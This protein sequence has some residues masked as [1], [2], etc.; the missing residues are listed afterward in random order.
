MNPRIKKAVSKSIQ[1]TSS[2][3]D[4]LWNGLCVASCLALKWP[5]CTEN[6]AAVKLSLLSTYVE[7]L[8]AISNPGENGAF[9]EVAWSTFAPKVVEGLRLDSKRMLM[10][11]PFHWLNFRQ[12]SLTRLIYSNRRKQRRLRRLL[13]NGSI[14]AGPL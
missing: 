14:P 8:R 6:L 1:R 13:S 3:M 2:P 7:Q 12:S 5:L 4:R 11:T 9:Q 10:S